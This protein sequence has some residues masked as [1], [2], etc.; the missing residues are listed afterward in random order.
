MHCLK[1]VNSIL[2]VSDSSEQGAALV[3]IPK[4][5]W[6]IKSRRGYLL[7]D[8]LGG[9]HVGYAQYDG[10]EQ[11]RTLNAGAIVD[12]KVDG[13]YVMSI[14]GSKREEPETPAIAFAAVESREAGGVFA[15]I[16]DEINDELREF[17]L[18]KLT[19]LNRNGHSQVE[20]DQAF[21][22]MLDTPEFL[23]ELTTVVERFSEQIE[24]G[25]HTLMTTEIGPLNCADG[26]PPLS[27]ISNSAVQACANKALNTMIRIGIPLE[28]LNSLTPVNRQECTDFLRDTITQLYQAVGTSL[29][30]HQ[31]KPFSTFEINRDIESV[32]HR[33]SVTCTPEQYQQLC[34]E[35]E[36]SA[37]YP[38]RL[39]G[40]NNVATVK[41]T[42]FAR[43]FIAVEFNGMKLRGG[44]DQTLFLQSLKA[45]GCTV[46]GMTHDN[47][48]VRMF[49]NGQNVFVLESAFAQAPNSSSTSAVSTTAVGLLVGNAR[50]EVQSVFNQQKGL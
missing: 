2:Y 11:Y 44:L 18:S 4:N 39:N 25:I 13:Q 23:T 43:G 3:L 38:I 21:F 27:S 42:D 47:Q 17:L 33:A 45:L 26:R 9:H 8:V 46:I 19:E 7:E 10:K 28:R 1:T 5:N 41:V 30:S 50:L 37:Y 32:Q 35:A 34:D 31:V 48:Q 24:N 36:S 16:C 15:E 6:E 14:V 12:V 40:S 22:N 29:T 20:T 49:D